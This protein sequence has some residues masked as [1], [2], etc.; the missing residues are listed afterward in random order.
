M[1]DG[2]MAETHWCFDESFSG[3]RLRVQSN[4]D[5]LIILLIRGVKPS[6]CGIH[7]GRVVVILSKQLPL[8]HL[9]SYA[10]HFEIRL[11]GL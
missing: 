9:T 10:Y 6:R 2:A 1:N 7:C 8:L 4:T 5:V 11:D 3:K